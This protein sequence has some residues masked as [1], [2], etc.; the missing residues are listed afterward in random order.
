M[1]NVT[2]KV[3]H[4]RVDL[5]EFCVNLNPKKNN[6]FCLA[7]IPKAT[8]SVKIDQITWDDLHAAVPLLFSIKGCGVDGCV[9]YNKILHHPEVT[10]YMRSSKFR[11][12]E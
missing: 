11:M 6:V 2:G 9:C 3:C 7:I 1:A 10:A 4:A 12:E 5:V 8:Q